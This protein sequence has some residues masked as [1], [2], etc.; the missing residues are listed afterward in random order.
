MV[1]HW[2]NALIER[3]NL[4]KEKD[5]KP[6]CIDVVR[7]IANDCEVTGPILDAIEELQKDGYIK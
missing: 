5:E 6:S 1:E 2:K 3:L 7:Y 4:K